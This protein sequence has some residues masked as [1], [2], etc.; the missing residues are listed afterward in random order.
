MF[1]AGDEAEILIYDS[2]LSAADRVKV[3]DYLRAKWATP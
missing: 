1:L 3:E 2:V